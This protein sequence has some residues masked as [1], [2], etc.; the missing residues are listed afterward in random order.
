MRA[1]DRFVRLKSIRTFSPLQDGQVRLFPLKT[2]SSC[3][4]DSLFGKQD[5]PLFLSWKLSPLSP[6]SNQVCA[7]RP[8]IKKCGD[9]YLVSA[10]ANSVEAFSVEEAGACGVSAGGSEGENQGGCDSPVLTM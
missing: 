9:F 3:W 7:F 2:T 8:E 5:S 6:C 4:Q 10:W 1:S